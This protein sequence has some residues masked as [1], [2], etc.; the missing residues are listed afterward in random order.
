MTTQFETFIAG[1]KQ[2]AIPPDLPICLLLA[3]ADAVRLGLCNGEARMIAGEHDGTRWVVIRYL[4]T[5]VTLLASGATRP[6]EVDK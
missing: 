2:Q 6:L 1:L 5:S 4:Q 3:Q